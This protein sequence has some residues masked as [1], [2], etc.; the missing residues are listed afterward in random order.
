MCGICLASIFTW[1]GSFTQDVSESPNGTCSSEVYTGSIC[2]SALQSLQ[3]CIPDRCGSTEVYILSD[4]SQSEIESHVMRLLGGL[5][6]LNAR[7]E[8][9]EAVGPFLCS[10]Y[11]GLCSSDN[12]PYLPSSRQCET[13][14]TETCAAEFEQAIGLLGRDALPQCETLSAVPTIEFDCPG[15]NSGSVFISDCPLILSY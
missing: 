9:L 14:A 2:R 5:E 3:N 11:F 13:I 1:Y 15:E 7:P 12:Q 8:C 4:T 10:Y 6:L